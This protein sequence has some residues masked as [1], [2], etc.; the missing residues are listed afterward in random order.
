[1]RKII[2]PLLILFVITTKGREGMWMPQLLK[3]LNENDMKSLGMQISAEDIYSINQSSLKDAVLQFGGGC[4]GELISGNGLLVTNHHCGFSQI[5]S[6]STIEKNYLAD[7]Y[8]SKSF[9]EEIPCPGLTVTFI[10]E[11]TEVTSAVLTGVSD[12]MNDDSRTALIKL[13]TDSIEKSVTG[14]LKGSVRQ[15]YYGN[16][17]YLFK[18]EVFSDIRFV[19]APP[20]SLG[21]FGGETDNWMWPRHT[22]DFSMFRIY[23]DKDNMPSPYSKDNRP[24]Q[25][26]RFLTINVGGVKENDFIFVYGFPGRTNKY[27]PS[28]GLDVI[29]SQTNPNRVAIRKV[30][31]DVM[32]EEIDKDEKVRLQYSPRFYTLEN[33]YKKWQ[34]EILGF[35]RFDPISIKKSDEEKFIS[36]LKKHP[37][38]IEDT[39]ILNE[40]ERI[41]NS[42]K[43]LNFVNDYYIEAFPGI[44]L[45]TTSGRFKKLV[46][47]CSYKEPDDN[48]IEE[49][50][51]KV[52]NDFTGFYKN[53]NSTLDKKICAAVLALTFSKLPKQF[54]PGKISQEGYKQSNF[55]NYSEWLFKNSLVADSARTMKFISSF[56]K[57]DVKKILDDPAYKLNLKIADIQS[58]VQADL[59]KINKDLNRLQ[60]KYMRDLLALDTSN[61]LYPEAN[62]T[63]RV[64]Y[65]RVEGTDPE[66]GIHYDYFATGNGIFIKSEM[67]VSDYKIPEEFSKL[68]KS[69]DFGRY[70]V[71]GELPVTFLASAHTTGGN[72]GSPVINAKGE[73]V[74]INFDRMWEGVLSDYYY[75]EKLCRN[76]CVDIRY[77][78]FVIEKYGKANRLIDEM[79][80]VN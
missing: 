13:R 14:T 30:R 68:L 4:T 69:H 54:I 66:D 79:K 56:K 8:W 26:R 78:L 10:R 38:M 17:Y 22:C 5:Q 23:A 21:K 27:L 1:M 77:V 33:P 46:E 58:R 35:N 60:K 15:F 45:T 24:Y 3:E 67:D 65:G 2:L 57:S 11:I 50:L 28:S 40:Y 41:S 43:S 51:K 80:I 6:L 47:L 73:L 36:D 18:L 74:G 48:L 20:K 70:G 63:L 76:I 12:T 59:N 7:G 44:E 52:K 42:G 61:K 29:A 55:V 25:P 37:E 71:N 39:S 49:E 53:Y 72:S 75:D 16:K 19:G 62:S 32:R 9:E 34:G 31:L 64:S